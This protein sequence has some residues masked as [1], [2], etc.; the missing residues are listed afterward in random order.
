MPI[1]LAALLLLLGEPPVGAVLHL[2]GRGSRRES[3][4]G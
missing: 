1:L 4:G 3:N 2:E